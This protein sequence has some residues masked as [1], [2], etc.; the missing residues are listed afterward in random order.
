M[1]LLVQ[2][3]NPG[4]S[5]AIRE[6]PKAASAKRGVEL[7]VLK[8]AKTADIETAFASCRQLRAAGLVVV[9]DPLFLAYVAQIAGLLLTLCRSRDPLVAGVR[10]CRW[11]D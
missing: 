4:T 11:P 5:S 6:L 8:A 7:H 9:K 2:P 1:A 3:T 10:R